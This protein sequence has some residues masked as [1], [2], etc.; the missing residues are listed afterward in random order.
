M[1]ACKGVCELKGK[2]ACSLD[3][4]LTAGLIKAND[5]R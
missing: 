1:S 3:S 5:Q 2:C 4:E